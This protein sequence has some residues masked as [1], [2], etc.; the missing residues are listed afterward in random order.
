MVAYVAQG[1]QENGTENPSY[2]VLEADLTNEPVPNT[3]RRLLKIFV[4]IKH[5]IFYFLLAFF[6]LLGL[7]INCHKP[8][9]P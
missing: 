6:M 3:V 8:N 4:V 1:K 2:Y 7:V 9:I 5:S